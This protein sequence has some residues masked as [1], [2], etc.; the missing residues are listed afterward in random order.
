VSISP[1][2][3]PFEAGD[4]LTCSAN[5]YDPSYMWTGTAGVNGDT[6]SESGVNYVLP[7]GPFYVIC[8]AAVSHLSCHDYATFNDTAYSTYNTLVTICE[9]L[10][11]LSEVV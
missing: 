1:S 2:T 4:E 9:K 7:E 6:I 10:T 5:G 3:G 8:T 11:I